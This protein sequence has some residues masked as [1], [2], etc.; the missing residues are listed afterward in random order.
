[1]TQVFFLSFK[2]L[3]LFSSSFILKINS[4]YKTKKQIQIGTYLMGKVG[5]IT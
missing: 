1:M 3:S 2:F 5:I 4:L